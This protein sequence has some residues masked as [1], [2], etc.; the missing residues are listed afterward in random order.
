ML[1][2]IL[3][4]GLASNV[5]GKHTIMDVTFLHLQVSK[6]FFPDV[7]VGFE[8]PRVTLHIG[9]GSQLCSVFSP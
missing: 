1:S 4:R 7:A 2:V 9:D 3:R 8:D 6:Q 5:M